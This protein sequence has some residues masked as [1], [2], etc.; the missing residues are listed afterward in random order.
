VDLSFRQDVPA[1]HTRHSTHSRFVCPRR[2]QW[3]CTSDKTCQLNTHDTPHTLD[4]CVHAAAS[5]LV[6][7]TRRASSTHTTLHESPTHPTWSPT[8]PGPGDVPTSATSS[9]RH[10]MPVCC[11]VGTTAL[12]NASAFSYLAICTIYHMLHFRTSFERIIH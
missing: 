10:G 7:L 2:C 1:Q 11:N 8:T 3:T 6:L 5:G 9:K 12:P 4:S